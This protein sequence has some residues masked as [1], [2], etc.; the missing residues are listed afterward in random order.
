MPLEIKRKENR[1]IDVLTLVGSLTFGHDVLVFRMVFD[2]LLDEGR[3]RVALNL[4]RLS[5]IDTTGV[6]TLLYASRELQKAGGGL[7]IFGLRA[8]LLEPRVGAKLNAPEIFAAEQEA[9]AS[10]V[11]REGV[12]HFD[13]LELVRAMKRER[14]HPRV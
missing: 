5:E 9:M 6:N 4:T 14:E 13:V 7:A 2:G 3:V 10:F 11:P 1:G 12:R 8:S